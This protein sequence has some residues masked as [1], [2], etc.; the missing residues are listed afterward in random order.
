MILIDVY[1]ILKLT[2]TDLELRS[3]ESIELTEGGE[4]LSR[5]QNNG[6]GKFKSKQE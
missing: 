3:L 2:E 4:E 6:I 1:E 5:Q